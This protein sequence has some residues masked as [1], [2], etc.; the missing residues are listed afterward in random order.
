MLDFDQAAGVIM[1]TFRIGDVVQT[2]IGGPS[3]I[4]ESVHSNY[5]GCVSV[6]GNVAKRL[7]YHYDEVRFVKRRSL[8]RILLSLI[9]AKHSST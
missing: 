1:A 8:I 6:E 2:I 5:I 3:M 7:E 9:T 4:V